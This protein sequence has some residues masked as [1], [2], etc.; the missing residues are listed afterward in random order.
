MN[1]LFKRH[2][3]IHL[4]ILT[5]QW[6]IMCFC[7]GAGWIRVGGRLPMVPLREREETVPAAVSCAALWRGETV[8]SKKERSHIHS[9]KLGFSFS[10]I[11]DRSSAHRAVHCTIIFDHT[12]IVSF[13]LQ[14]LFY[15]TLQSY[16]T[17]WPRDPLN[18]CFQRYS[19][20][21]ISVSLKR[22]NYFRWSRKGSAP[23]RKCGM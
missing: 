3:R 7:L 1:G 6:I 12:K 22:L 5:S 13:F 20:H 16:F 10:F 18:H 8:C 19:S 9:F 2:S 21:S 11:D 4:C 15:F 14:S 23:L 17:D